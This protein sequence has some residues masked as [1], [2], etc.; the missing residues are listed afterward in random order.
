[1][2]KIVDVTKDFKNGKGVFDFSLELKS[3]QIIGLVG[4]NGSGKSTLLKSVFNEYK[5]DTGQ[6]LL[7]EESIYENNNFSKICFF[8]DQSVYPKDISIYQ[9][10]VHD[11][12]LC[13][14][15]KKEAVARL[16]MLLEKFE[17]KEYREKTFYELSAG[18][19]KR[20]MLVI[21]LVTQPE[22][23]ILDE[24]TANLDVGTRIEFHKIL[25]ML[26][27]EGVGILITSHM[28]NELEE[29]IDHLVIIEKGVTKYNKAFNNKKESIETIYKKSTIQKVEKD[30]SEIY[31]KKT[32]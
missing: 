28:I 12:L 5:K 23:L 7:N 29:M 1:M 6:V 17:L 2:L 8:P 18:M 14:M 27:K 13:G 31:S 26:S 16:D 20:A 32:N 4:D 9:F 24:P 22:Y 10:A 19:Q 15:N 21:C 3:G 30:Y 11:A 25:K